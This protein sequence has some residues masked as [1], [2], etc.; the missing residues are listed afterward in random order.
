MFRT[1]YQANA[2]MLAILLCA[3][4]LVAAPA[5]A[6]DAARS[7]DQ[8]RMVASLGETVTVTDVTGRAT[9]G[10]LA[11]LSSSSLALLI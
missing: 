4:G 5:S 10:T 9:T 6:Q 11:D 3:S 1:C 8:L 7:F 2:G